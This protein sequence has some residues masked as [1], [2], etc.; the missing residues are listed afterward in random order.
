MKYVAVFGLVLLPVVAFA[1]VE[2]AFVQ[3]AQFEDNSQLLSSLSLWATIIIA[4][5]TSVMV[6]L[7]GRKMR[8]GVFGK[9]LAYFS[10]GMMLIFFGF[11]AQIF[12]T[13][14]TTAIYFDLLH[15]ALYTLG[16]IFMGVAGNK[17]L[18]TVNEK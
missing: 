14:D 16:Y 12:S 1:G 7:G 11:V 17:L 9:V 3:M 13:E 4:F 6:W 18:R 10:I 2:N 15:G 5:V 8:G